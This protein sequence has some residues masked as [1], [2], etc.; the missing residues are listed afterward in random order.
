M[1]SVPLRFCLC[2]THNVLFPLSLAPL[3]SCT[4][5]PGLRQRAPDGGQPQ[6]VYRM[7]TQ[8]ESRVE[9]RGERREARGERREAAG[10]LQSAQDFDGE[11]SET[12]RRRA[13]SSQRPQNFR[14]SLPEQGSR[15][16]A[17]QAPS[18][19]RH[20]PLR[21]PSRPRAECGL[22]P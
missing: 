3:L 13:R 11:L 2:L 16:G 8:R 10:L 20:S 15:R 12:S 9:S 7:L 14:A 22:T 19:R 4:H 1:P 21:R 6:A 18:S 17:Q 5:E